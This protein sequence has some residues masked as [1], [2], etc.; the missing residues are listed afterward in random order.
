M[1]SHVLILLIEMPRT[2]KDY[3]SKFNQYFTYPLGV[4]V[5]PLFIFSICVSFKASSVT[6]DDDKMEKL[7]NP[8]IGKVYIIHHGNE[9][10]QL[11]NPELN[12]S[13]FSGEIGAV[14]D[15]HK[16]RSDQKYKK[17]ESKFENA[18]RSRRE[19]H[20]F[21]KDGFYNF[22]KGQFIELD[23]GDILEVKLYESIGNTTENIF[24]VTLGS[25][26]AIIP[27]AEAT[28]SSCPFAY[29]Y[30]GKDYNL[31]GEIFSGS[32]FKPME[33]GDFLKLN[34]LFPHEGMYKIVISNE[35]KEV[36]Y[37][38]QL[39]LMVANAPSG[40]KIL[41][42]QDGKPHSIMQKNYC[43]SC[44][45]ITKKDISYKLYKS[46][47]Q[48]YLFDNLDYNVN[49]LNLEFDI[50]TG[51]KSMK[52]VLKARS[53]FWVDYI[54]ENIPDFTTRIL[55]PLSRKETMRPKKDSLTGKT[56]RDSHLKFLFGK[57]MNGLS[58]RNSN[59][60]ALLLSGR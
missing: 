45:D 43:I 3:Y 12:G 2:M 52:L 32:I 40:A 17:K 60:L 35:L 28:K 15:A 7:E 10:W 55:T 19:I 16:T 11:K 13:Y 9:E 51:S 25:F 5:I 8:V 44:T 49:Q 20:L 56:K 23:I 24:S 22:Q 4:I 31:E 42:D 34:Y 21:L 58:Y 53:S 37:I 30:N 50:P 54:W 1:V 18:K 47:D 33:R 36:Q 27:I 48:T 46:D 14:T 39:E 59:T 57:I 26:A 41:L 6:T 38:N 29:S